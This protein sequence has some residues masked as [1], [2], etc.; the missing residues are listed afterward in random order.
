MF[1]FSNLAI[2]LDGKIATASREP[3]YLG[4]PADR[5]Q[6]QVLRKRADIVL[7]GAT[8]LRAYK[9]FCGVSGAKPGRQIANAILSSKLEGIRP[10]FLFFS[11]SEQKRLLFVTQT[12]STARLKAFSRSSEVIPLT[13]NAPLAR[14]MILALKKRGFKRL[15]VEGGGA[16]MWDFASQNLIDEYHVT[17]T[18]KIVG[19]RDSPT[20][21][22]GEGFTP[23]RILGLKLARCKRLGDELYL[24]YQ[25]R[26]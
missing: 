24:T 22:E 14:Q 17:L 26:T 3:F 1:V 19:G 15:L 25:K 21:V 10:D 7:M 8:T 4:T 13:G 23:A 9:K 2:S 6:M 16:L 18:P 5:A 12:L 20:L 11:D